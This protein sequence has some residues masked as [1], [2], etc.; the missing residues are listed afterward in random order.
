MV[1]REAKIITPTIPLDQKVDVYSIGATLWSLV[2]HNIRPEQPIWLGN[3]NPENTLYRMHLPTDDEDPRIA[4]DEQ[5]KRQRRIREKRSPS[6]D[7]YGEESDDDEGREPTEKEKQDQLVRTYS[8]ELRQLIVDCLQY[9]LSQRPSMRD[10]Q[11]RVS[12]MISN[13]HASLQSLRNGT[14]DAETL[15]GAE[16]GCREDRYRIGMARD[17]LPRRSDLTRIS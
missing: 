9:N 16:V 5:E 6:A 3:G 14:A 11:E 7:S 1:D 12:I 15:R 17:R 2:A 13:N 4:A 10:L 8:N